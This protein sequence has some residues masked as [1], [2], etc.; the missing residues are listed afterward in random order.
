MASIETP[1]DLTAILSQ[2]WAQVFPLLEKFKA[3]DQKGRYLHWHELKHRLPSSLDKHAAWGAIKLSRQAMR[4]EID[5]KSADAQ[6]FHFCVP[7][8]LQASLHQIDRLLLPFSVASTHFT[9]EQES[10]RFLVESL[11][12]EEAISSAQLEGAATTRKAAKAMLETERTPRNEDE[13]MVFNNFALMKAVRAARAEPLSIDLI[14]HLHYTA[15]QGTQNEQVIPGAFRQHDDVVVQGRH[16]E[17]LHQPPPAAEIHRRLLRLCSF[18]NAPHDGKAGRDFIHPV[19]KAVILHF[20]TAY[21]HSFAD[22]N[23]RTARALFYW[24]MLKNGYWMFEYISIS[25]LLKNAPVQYGESYLFT[26]TD[27]FDLTY[28]IDYQFRVIGRATENFFAYL[29]QRRK[30]RHDVLALLDQ[31]GITGR[32][33][34]RQGQILHKALRNPGRVF[35]VKEVKHDFGVTETTARLDL[36]KLT[37]MKVFALARDGKVVNYVSR[38]DAEQQLRR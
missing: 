32:L 7:G 5:L 38:A 12:M 36:D 29:E 22:G 11:M 1:P 27:G 6:P 26:E 33:N 19:I 9:G 17:I 10:N 16:G 15:T 34:E 21:E 28:F 2:Q 37:Q 18:A 31:M 25:A 30:A 8:S 4:H 20:M 35:T 23:G 24:F 14:A 3:V 13:R